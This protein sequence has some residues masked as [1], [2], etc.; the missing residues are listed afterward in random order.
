[1]DGR[2][3]GEFSTRSG[4]GSSK[5]TLIDNNDIPL[6]N[7]STV[8]MSGAQNKSVAQSAAPVV[9]ANPNLGEPAKPLPGWR[10]ALLGIG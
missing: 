3:T 10:Y 6:H 2:T 9:L 4:I 5:D 1:M 8:A 7:M